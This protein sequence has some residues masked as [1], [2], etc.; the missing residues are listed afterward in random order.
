MSRTAVFFLTL[1]FTSITSVNAEEISAA[2]LQAIG[3]EVRWS[4]QATLDVR[5]DTVRFVT[6]DEANVYVQSSSGMLTAFHAEN[7]RRLWNAQVG[8]TDEAGMMAVSNSQIVVAVAGPSIHGFNK[9]NGNRLFE[10]RL[11]AQPSAAPGLSEGALF[12]PLSGGAMYAYSLGVLQYRSKYGKLPDIAITPH[13]W[14]F[15]CAEDITH[16]PV[17][18]ER[19]IS[20]ATE[21][22]S[23]FSVETSGIAR[24]QTRCQLLMNGSASADLA[25]A[26]NKGGSSVLMVTG[27]NRIFSIDMMTG[28]TEWT[29]P[30]GRKMTQPPVVIGNHVYV[31]AT[32]G[33]MIKIERDEFS[34][35][36]GRPVETPNWQYP[37]YIGAGMAS[38]D[39]DATAQGAVVMNV[40]P[41]STADATGLQPGDVITMIDGLTVDNVEA[42]QSAI[43]E[44]PVRVERGIEVTR[45]DTTE[46]LSIRVP[47]IKWEAPGVQ[48]FTTVGRFSVY[49]IDTA[50][51]LVGFDLKTSTLKGRVSI[52]GY[53]KHHH[54]TA[55]DQVYLVSS[56]G[57]VICMREI[58]PTVKLPE[59]STVSSEARIKS[60]MVRPGAVIEATGT[61]ICEVE[62][63]DGDIQQIT[64]NQPGEVREIF[65]RTGQIVQTGDPL[66]LIA[67]DKFATYHQNPQQRPIDVQLNDPN[68]AAPTDDD[69]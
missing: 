11:P 49:G 23:L 58:G 48:K 55:T 51:R 16:P 5:R 32:D 24:G 12:I 3:L 8:H 20:F 63:P 39:E 56:S 36:W 27:E 22:K 38:T 40:V 1:F 34:P 50:D 6:N 53:S 44:L 14:R 54:N 31:V 65:A 60:V 43:A 42:A 57:E 18:G 15:I 62:L 59:L 68:A 4:S 52:Q 41:G 67:D 66:I 45:G 10:F 33:T 13:M 29:Y 19:A 17:V 28:N 47:P 64:S 35:S 30:M 46:R 7:G 2:A 25:V 69:L 26:D 21:S 61:V 9:F 37:M